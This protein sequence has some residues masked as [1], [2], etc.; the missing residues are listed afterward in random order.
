MCPALLACRE[1]TVPDDQ[2]ILLLATVDGK[3]LPTALVTLIELDYPN[4]EIIAVND[5]S[6][7]ATPR[8]LDE[9]ASTHPRLKVVHINDLPP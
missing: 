2:V 8:I 5:R 9:F 4:L 1:T 6:T 3:T 7:D